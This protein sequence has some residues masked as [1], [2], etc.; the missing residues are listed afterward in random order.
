MW[1]CT[2]HYWN[3]SQVLN[4]II[5]LWSCHHLVNNNPPPPL[6]IPLAQLTIIHG[7]HPSQ[8]NL[9]LLLA[10]LVV[11]KGQCQSTGIPL[12][13]LVIIQ[14]Q[15]RL[16]CKLLRLLALLVIGNLAQGP[17]EEIPRGLFII[18]QEGV[19]WK[20]FHMGIHLPRVVIWILTTRQMPTERIF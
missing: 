9:L 7:H 18:I 10:L 1:L 6:G 11:S 4:G 17:P 15:H 3:K 13:Q 20:G 8:G 19:R 12:A 5:H 14:G 16:Q 2:R